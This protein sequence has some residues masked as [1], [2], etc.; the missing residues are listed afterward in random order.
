M[1]II[2]G[3]VPACIRYWR[4][5][6]RPL[7]DKTPT[8]PRHGWMSQ[9]AAAD[10]L[11]R[12]FKIITRMKDLPAPILDLFTEAH[13]KRL[14]M[15]DPGEKF[16]STDLIIDESVPRKRLIFAGVANESCFVYYEQGGR[17]LHEVVEFF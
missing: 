7:A 11:S 5:V 6:H 8:V 13:G 12:D 3:A 14:L 16:E 17:G 4:W 15:A 9:S 2:V 1:G 10:L